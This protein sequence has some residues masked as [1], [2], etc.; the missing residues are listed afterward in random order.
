MCCMKKW[1]WHWWLGRGLLKGRSQEH[2]RSRRFNHNCLLILISFASVSQS[3]R[4]GLLWNPGMG[5]ICI[6]FQMLKMHKEGHFFARQARKMSYNGWYQAGINWLLCESTAEKHQSRC[7]TGQIMQKH[8]QQFPE[9]QLRKQSMQ[10]E[11]EPWLWASPRNA[12]KYRS[13][14]RQCFILRLEMQRDHWHGWYLTHE[15]DYK[16]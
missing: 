2:T 16:E 13:F 11:T 9:L 5:H 7:I 14:T 10:K 1:E 3:I 6:S 8:N 12:G 4:E 15:G